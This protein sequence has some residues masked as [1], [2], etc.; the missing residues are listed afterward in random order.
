MASTDGST[1]PG[2]AGVFDQRSTSEVVASLIANVQALFRTEVELAKLE[3]T[4]IIK[5]KAVAIV[6]LIVS[7][8][9]GLFVLGFAGVTGAN[10]FMLLV[11]PWLA[12]LFITLIYLLVVL[13]ATL[14]ALRL[15]KKP[16]SPERTKA[17]LTETKEWAQRQV[18]R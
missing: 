6:L 5:D 18:Q 14:W 7:A 12:W 15:L 3:I 8:V 9:F 2:E 10:A 17:E 4:G 13:V 11:S 1:D 16:S